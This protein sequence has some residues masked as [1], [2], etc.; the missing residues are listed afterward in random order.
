[1]LSFILLILLGQ[2]PA[3]SAAQVK[4]PELAK[5]LQARFKKDQDAR[6]KL[7]DFMAKHRLTGGIKLDTLEASV[8]AEFQALGHRVQEIDK[9]N[10]AWMKE[11]V[12]KH[13]WPGKSLIGKAGAANAWLLVQHADA[14]RDF[15]ELCLGKM[16]ALPAGEVEGRHIAYLTDR[17]LVGRGKKQLYGTQATLNGGKAVPSPLEDEVKVDQRRKEVGLGP[18]AEYLKQLEKTYTKPEAK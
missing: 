12:K 1:M 18:L 14:D 17:V 6:F 10:V 9:A 3:D 5:E 2:P 15:Q 13:G 4:E 7:I 8:Q 16:K 11:V